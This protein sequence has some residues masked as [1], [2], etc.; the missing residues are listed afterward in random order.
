MYRKKESRFPLDSLYMGYEYIISY[1]NKYE[2][3]MLT[4][5]G[6]VKAPM[7]N[8]FVLLV[9]TRTTELLMALGL[10]T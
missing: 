4:K 5:I 8:F 2:L 6:S 10:G 7:V 1:L 9:A 3:I